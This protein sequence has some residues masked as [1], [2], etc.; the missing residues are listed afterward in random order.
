MGEST[1]TTKGGGDSEEEKTF[2][3]KVREKKNMKVKES[4]KVKPPSCRVCHRRVCRQAAGCLRARPDS[5]QFKCSVCPRTFTHKCN[6]E[7]H[8]RV[9]SGERPFRCTFAAA[10]KP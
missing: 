8:L 6:F 3:E 10:R 4:V 2:E 5:R 7:S 9:H 1:A